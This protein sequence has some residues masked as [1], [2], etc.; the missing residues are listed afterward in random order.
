MMWVGRDFLPVQP[1]LVL[2]G[3]MG[4]ERFKGPGNLV[5]GGSRHVRY[6]KPAVTGRP[7][8]RRRDVVV[9]IGIAVAV[10][11]VLGVLVARGSRSGSGIG[12][13]SSTSAGLSAIVNDSTSSTGD[14]NSSSAASD[15]AFVQEA[16]SGDAGA[17]AEAVL[18]SEGVGSFDDGVDTQADGEPDGGAVN[19]GVSSVKQGGSES[20]CQKDSTGGSV[21]QGA[22]GS[23]ADKSDSAQDTAGGGSG[24]GSSSNQ[25]G[26]SKGDETPG[27]GAIID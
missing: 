13:A 1:I 6:A 10:C 24:D 15:T 27:F 19:S 5:S 18:P 23:S 25:G 7:S 9:G 3:G 17:S 21:T 22:N 16:V 4:R 20:D 8:P 12:S 14:S 26:Q 11:V 2:G